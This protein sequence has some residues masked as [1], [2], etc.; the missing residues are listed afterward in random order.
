MLHVQDSPYIKDVHF[1][2]A[3]D[4][5]QAISYKG[6]F[7]SLLG[8]HYIFRGHSTDLYELLPSALR[9]LLAYDSM[10]IPKAF[11]EEERKKAFYLSTT[12]WGQIQKE[13]KLL[14]DFFNA[15][16][17]SGLYVP[18]VESLRNSFYPGIDP[19]TVLLKTKWLPKTYWELAAL[20][21]HHGV[22]T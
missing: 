9:G 15:C 3:T 1:E 22:A 2:N 21:Q 13:N 19:E 17:R 10:R 6:Q 18:H 11:T 20:A 8:S 4:F 16:D 12:E 5:I 7:Y 14:Q